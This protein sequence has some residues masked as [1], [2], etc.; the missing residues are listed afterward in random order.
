M[1][2][3][4]PRPMMGLTPRHSIPAPIRRER[5]SKWTVHSSEQPSKTKRDYD[6]RIRLIFNGVAQRFFKRTG[7]LPRGFCGC[8]GNLGRAVNHGDA[9]I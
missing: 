7:S 4:G 6:S 5:G 3:A 2:V 9:P 8:V 1:T